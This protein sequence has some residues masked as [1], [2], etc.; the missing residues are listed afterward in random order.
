MKQVLFEDMYCW[1]VFNEM[2]QIDF[3]GHLWVRPEGNV[4]IDPVPMSAA[5]LAQLDTLGGAALIVVTNTDHER[6]STFFKEHTGADVIVHSDDADVLAVDSDRLVEDGEEIVTGLQVVHLRYGK[7]PGEMALYWPERQLILAGDLVVGAP[8]GKFSLLMDEK[9]QDPARAA[10]QLRK[11]LAL[12]FD[13][14]L[15]GD[16]H[17][18]MH[19]AKEKLVE[20]LEARSD[21]YINKINL[22]EMAWQVSTGPKGYV[23]QSKD[24]DPLVGARRLGYQLIRLGAGQSICPLH[25]HHFAEELFYVMAGGCTLRTSRGDWPVCEGDF[26]AFPPGPDGAHKFINERGEQCVLL[27]LGEQLAHDVC[28][29][30]DSGKI[31]VSAKGATGEQI[32][33]LRDNVG[34]W[35]GE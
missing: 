30:P 17:S 35:Q 24:I 15:V 4:L 11:L 14:I 2:R 20:C 21:I 3:N 7:S 28:E 6:E 1:S 13:A 18:I 8:L 5:D 29:Y 32:Y 31:N 26:I 16:G 25:F 12:S 9:L 10:L 23:K 33:R 22:D 27:A 34:Y 19:G